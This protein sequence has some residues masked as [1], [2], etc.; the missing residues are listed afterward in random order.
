MVYSIAMP[1]QIESPEYYSR[2]LYLVYLKTLVILIS[3]CF[4]QMA[5]AQTHKINFVH[6]TVENGLSQ[7]S[8]LSIAQDSIGF[9]WFG[10]K[11]GLNKFN[12]QTFEIFKH[13]KDDT[14]SLSSSQN[15]NAL[16]TD[17]KGNLWVGTQNGLNLYLR[18]SN[19]FRHFFIPPAANG[20]LSSNVIRSL[21][22]DRQGGLWVGTDDGLYKLLKNGKFQRIEGRSSDGRLFRKQ[23]I[24][25]V[26]Q[27]HEGVLWIAA[28]EGLTRISPK[29]KYYEFRCFV[30]D[31]NDP[32]SLVDNDVT[33]VIEDRQHRLWIGTHQYG[34]ELFDRANSTFRRVKP[35]EDG[36]AAN[37]GDVIRKLTLDKDGRIWIGMLNGIHLFDPGKNEFTL[38]K[39]DA[40]IPTSLNQN[41]IYDIHRDAAGSMWI[42]TY[43]GGINVYHVDA[44][45]FKGYKSFADQNSLSSNVVSA[46]VEDGQHHLWIGTEAEGLNYYDRSS[47]LFKSFKSDA[48]PSGL[49]SNLIKAIAI[50]NKKRV[51]IGT[52]EG[53][54]DLYLP[55]NN[56]FKH[57]SG[58]Y[59][60]P[61]RLT[62][63]RIT[64]LLYDHQNRLWAGT[65][66]NGMY[67]YDEKK[68]AFMS[69]DEKLSG[70]KTPVRHIRHLFED[71]G[72]N[73][74][75]A[76]NLGTYK[77]S[78]HADRFTKVVPGKSRIAL[79]DI[80]VISED[81]LGKIWF[82]SYELG[83]IRYDPVKGFSKNYTIDNGLPSN[84]I[85]GILEDEGGNL[86][87]STDN[88]LSK[89]NGRVFKNYT[90]KDGLPG[91]VFNYNSY[92]KDSRGEFFFGGYNGLLSFFPAR[93]YKPEAV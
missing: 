23:L 35:A 49:S 88:G 75:A 1:N 26:Y 76:T 55:G 32:Q 40:D 59:T 54:L 4:M 84:V 42:G 83:L 33:S 30:H 17:H 89:F 57:Y 43:Y 72:G 62:S 50:D 66:A 91:N 10:T 77:L 46:I 70:K 25:S 53:G 63:R 8:V 61:G 37:N 51:W 20:E 78:R 48:G 12:T 82:G 80:N 15:I 64:C 22:E 90:I 65:R 85:L 16:L 14:S 47:G 92:L 21:Y 18:K 9:M 73:V 39:H 27:D 58:N 71:T 31:P 29:G 60:D 2:S 6:H 5:G 19:S 7:S 93:I 36:I 44:M 28:M 11:D 74:W 41:S 34:L 13:K 86:W 56:T 87:I 68:D 3:F 69:C 81:R 38:L 79:D 52:Y 67:L 24:K 45:P